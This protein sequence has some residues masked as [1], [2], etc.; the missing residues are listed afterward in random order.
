MR[1]I[2]GFRIGQ[3]LAQ[4]TTAQLT[5]FIARFGSTGTE[6]ANQLAVGTLVWDTTANA[7][8]VYNGTAFVA[9]ATA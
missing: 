6:G 1:N 7:V 2:G 3:G 8:K 5:D 9:L 4:F